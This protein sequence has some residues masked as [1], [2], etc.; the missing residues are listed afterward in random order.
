MNTLFIDLISKI[1]SISEIILFAM[2]F[3]FLNLML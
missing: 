2:I 3:S 1:L